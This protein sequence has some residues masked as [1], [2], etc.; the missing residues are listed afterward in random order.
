MCH[1]HCMW[2][3]VVVGLMLLLGVG[4]S[5]SRAQGLKAED[6]RQIGEQGFGLRGNSYA[7]SMAYFKD[8]LYIGTNHNFLCIVRSIRGV[9]ANNA[10]QEVPVDCDP[11]L[12]DTDLR[13]RIYTYDPATQEIELVYISPTSKALSSDGTFRDVAVD[14]GYR[15]MLV[16]REPDGREALYVGTYVTTEVPGPPPRILRSVDGR[17]FEALPGKISNDAT[18]VSYRSLTS[19]KGR[20]YVLGIGRVGEETTL[21]EAVDPASGEFI[22]VNPPNFGDPANIS[23]F[24]LEAFKGFLYIGTATDDQG[25]QLLKTQAVGRPPY[26]F[27]KVLTKGAYRGSRNQNVVSLKAF[28]DYLYVGT[29]LN[30]VALDFFP[31]VDSAAAELLRV[32]GD[33]SWQVVC[34][35]PRETPD[36]YKFPITGKLGGCGNSRT[37]YIWRMAVHD[38]RLYMG[39]FDM[40]LFARFATTEGLESSIDL[41]IRPIISWILERIPA[42]EIADVVAAIDGGFDLWETEDGRDWKLITRNGLEDEYAYGIRSLASTPYGLFVGTANPYFGFRLFLGQQPG[43]D[44]DGDSW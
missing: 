27:E 25:F 37:G 11:N 31:G 44:L 5:P 3:T 18:L 15:S 26:V 21:L 24:E 23:A 43:A 12:L 17:H 22:R 7:W 4:T 9:T 29:G 41:D 16:H 10:E 2:G 28:G 36:G 6:F 32:A 19:Y 35:E 14:L 8:R 1:R 33:G 40:S 30:F 20:L 38:N 34:G 13:G 42:G 39:T